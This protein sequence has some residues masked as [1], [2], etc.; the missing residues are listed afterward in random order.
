[1]WTQEV[2]LEAMGRKESDH[3]L[4]MVDI[5]IIDPGKCQTDAG[6][7]NWQISFVNKLCAI[8][9]AANVPIDYIVRPEMDEDNELFLKKDETRR[10]I[11]RCH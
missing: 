10:D 6:W 2:M 1:M 3:N 5:D 7:D 11:T 4:D 9:G 8:M